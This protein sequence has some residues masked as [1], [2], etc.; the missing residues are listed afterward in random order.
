MP[1]RLGLPGGSGGPRG[2]RR[3]GRATAPA[4]RGSSPRRPGSSWPPTPSWSCSRAGS[5]PRWS[6]AA[7]TPGSS[8]PSP[9]P[10]RPPKPDG[11]ETTEAGWFAPAAALEAQA[12][13]EMALAFP[14][15]A[16]LQILAPF[17][18][19]AEAIE[20]YRGRDV[21][22]ILPK[23]IGTQRGAPGRAPRR[24]RLPELSDRPAPRAGRA[25]TPRTVVPGATS[26]VTTAPAP[27]TASSPISTPGRI[28]R[29]RRSGSRG[30]GPAA[31]CARTEL[32]V[33]PV[34]MIT[35]GAE[36]AV[37][38]DHGS[39]PDHAL[40]LHP[41]AIAEDDVRLPIPTRNR[42]RHRRRSRPP[43]ERG[44]DRR[45]WSAGAHPRARV[46]SA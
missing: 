19:A 45:A 11:V 14:T 29:R 26:A 23:V 7:S 15:I 1:G 6:R 10:I 33:R 5:R 22:P 4:R 21:E 27:I 24:P 39:G 18:T 12:A 9:R 32:I 36:E 37:L 35:P 43:P 46:T 16:Q 13:G 44:R 42:R 41:G 8:S 38:L 34:S 30:A 17:A 25:G 40:V 2:R 31:A 20:A 28:S 3:R